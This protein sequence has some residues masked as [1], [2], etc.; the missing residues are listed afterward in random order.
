MRQNN[1]D[2]VLGGQPRQPSHILRVDERV[3]VHRCHFPRAVWFWVERKLRSV[4]RLAVDRY[5]E[6]QCLMMAGVAGEKDV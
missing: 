5:G 2:I 6:V 4:I 3:F 1:H